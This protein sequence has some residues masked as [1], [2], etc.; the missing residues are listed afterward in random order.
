[1]RSC[2]FSFNAQE[3][4]RYGLL[5]AF[6]Y[7]VIIF[8]GG[9]IRLP[10]FSCYSNLI[11]RALFRVCCAHV[12][13]HTQ[14]PSTSDVPRHITCT[15]S[16]VFRGHRSQQNVNSLETEV[17]LSKMCDPS[18]LEFLHLWFGG[19][20]EHLPHGFLW[21]LW[22]N[23]H[24]V[25]RIITSTLWGPSKCELM[26]LLVVDALPLKYFLATPKAAGCCV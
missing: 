6:D 5:V 16:N 25:L 24:K 15:N 17:T 7:P 22:V 14:S 21:G 18:V 19:I 8:H 3:W 12:F 26:L 13:Q 2:Y 4:I 1:M 20:E 10:L 9:M 23:T 11:S